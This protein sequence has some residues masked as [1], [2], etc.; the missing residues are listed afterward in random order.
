MNTTTAADQV[1]PDVVLQDNGNF[2]I[3]W[4]STAQ[5]DPDSLPDLVTEL[6]RASTGASNAFYLRLAQRLSAIESGGEPINAWLERRLTSAGLELHQAQVELQQS[7]ASTQVSI[8]NSITSIRFLDAYEWREFFERVSL[9]EQ[10][11]QGRGRLAK[12]AA[13]NLP[14]RL[15]QQPL[16]FRVG[17]ERQF[18][19]RLFQG[20]FR[21]GW[22]LRRRRPSFQT[23]NSRAMA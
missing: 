19:A 13:V 14:A 18:R 16:E 20:C 10:V 21:P 11:L 6:D 17:F 23:W 12:L 22:F 8:A 4:T 5:D 7:R 15:L 2:T 1:T 3:V 9:V